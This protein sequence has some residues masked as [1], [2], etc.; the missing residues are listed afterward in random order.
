MK[1]TALLF[2]SLLYSLIGLCR[3]NSD[4]AL[5]NQR[6]KKSGRLLE[7]NVDS[8]RT[9]ILQ[10]LDATY[11]KKYA[12]GYS[13]SN[14]QLANYYTLKGQNDSALLFTAKAIKFAR[15]S[16]DTNHIIL[17]Y[18][19][20]ARTFA[21]LN[22]YPKAIEHCL[23]AQNFADKKKDNTCRIKIAHDLGFIY[24]NMNLHEK[25]I[26]Y[27]KKGLG[28]AVAQKD[29][30]NTANITARIGGE[31]N[32]L[33]NFDSGLYYNKKGLA[34]FKLLKHK[35]GIGATLTN[36]NVSYGGLKN[37]SGQMATLQEALKIRAELGDLYAIVILKNTLADCYFNK[38]DYKNAL[39]IAKEV[40]PLTWEQKQSALILQN[41]SLQYKANLNL[42]NHKEALIYALRYIDLSDSIYKGT[43]LKDISELQAKYE[44]DKKEKEILLLQL[45]KKNEQAKTESEN[46]K[47]NLFLLSVIL[48]TAI[49]LIFTVILYL[50]FKKINEQNLVI[51]KQKQ[52]VDEKNKEI[53]DSINYARTIQQALIPSEEEIKSY[54]KDAFVIFKP[55]DIVS[56]DFFWCNKVGNYLFVAVADCTGHGVPGAFMSMMGMSFLNEIITEKSIFEPSEILNKLREKVTASL[57]KDYAEL[58]KSDGMDMVLLRFDQTKQQL[59]FSG[60]NNTIYHLSNNHLTEMKGDKMPVGLHYGAMDS[61]SDVTVNLSPGDKILACTDGLPDQF[62]GP[63]GKKFMYKKLEQAIIDFGNADLATLKTKIES[64]LES[65][66]GSNEQIDDITCLAIEV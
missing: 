66:Q 29:T 5:L 54:T 23:V 57:N 59:K 2:L 62:G 7:S 3:L 11:K 44:S 35:R 10:N 55:K 43:N 37:Y 38:G 32:L 17:M 41:F 52:L 1:K 15:T 26:D 47:R 31:F 49:I 46:T 63:K 56:G 6:I 18:L 20:S 64:D 45:E 65:W 30:F 53:I 51:E 42:G 21:S 58:E 24:S 22:N 33:S 34:L 27:F 39:S 36:L 14:S 50:R 13:K 61:F 40:E 25:A 16:K 12:Y 8:A 48:I 60:A 9:L 28:Y 19:Q 4:T